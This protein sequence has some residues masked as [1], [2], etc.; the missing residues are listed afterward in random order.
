MALSLV[1]EPNIPSTTGAPTWRAGSPRSEQQSARYMDVDM[2]EAN[3][4]MAQEAACVAAE[5][6]SHAV[7]A[8]NVTGPQNASRSV[9]CSSLPTVRAYSIHPRMAVTDP[10]RRVR[11]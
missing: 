11:R 9:N 1:Y 5:F 8:A 10:T 4:L 7:A 6:S 3:V 2:S